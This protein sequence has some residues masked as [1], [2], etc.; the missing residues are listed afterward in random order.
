MFRSASRNSRTTWRLVHRVP[1]AARPGSATAWAWSGA[2]GTATL[3]QTFVSAKT[4]S[5][6]CVGI[7]VL[8]SQ[9]ETARRPLR[10][11]Q[12]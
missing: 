8:S 3:T 9:A 2:V 1:V 11:R 7:Q 4:P 6:A 12:G 10:A 5:T